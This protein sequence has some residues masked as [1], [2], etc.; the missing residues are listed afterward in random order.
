MNVFQGCLLA[1]FC[2][3]SLG[4]PNTVSAA[5]PEKPAIQEV[6]ALLEE[7]KSELSRDLRQ[8]R[9]E[10]AALRA[11]LDQPGIREVF[12]GVGYIFGLFGVAAFVAARRRE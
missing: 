8:I 2:L 6:L 10:I 1:V 9:R 11:D 3:L 5:S 4:L 7:H 12:A